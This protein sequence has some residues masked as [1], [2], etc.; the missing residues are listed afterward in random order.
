M[1]SFFLFYEIVCAATRNLV[2][3]NETLHVLALIKFLRATSE[4]ENAY[5]RRRKNKEL[6][7]Y[8]EKVSEISTYPAT[9]SASVNK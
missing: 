3:D 8:E 7:L 9:L 6:Y 1:I 2:D 4:Q 5:L